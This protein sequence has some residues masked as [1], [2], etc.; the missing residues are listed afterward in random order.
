MDRDWTAAFN[1]TFSAPASPV[2][3]DVWQTVL[4][5]EYVPGLDAY[6]Y[7]T[8]T[9]LGRI[10]AA[11][12]LEGE[13]LIADLGCGRGGPGLWVAGETGARLVGIDIAET[14][15]HAAEARAHDLGLGDRAT[16]RLGTFEDLRWAM[17]TS[18]EP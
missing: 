5:D 12:H 1:E 9:E 4:G 8:R 18:R 15:V 6:S 10:A 7:I 13:E 2:F 3:A 14:A 16:F 17:G 11:L